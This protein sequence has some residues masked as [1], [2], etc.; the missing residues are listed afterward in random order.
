VRVQDLAKA[1]SA[2][3]EGGLADLTEHSGPYGK[4]LLVQPDRAGGSWLE[5]F[6]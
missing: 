5:L 2:L 1:K 3:A 6:E 4:S